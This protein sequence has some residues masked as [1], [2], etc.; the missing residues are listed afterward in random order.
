MSAS[1]R[2][3]DQEIKV[4]PTYTLFELF[5]V[6]FHPLGSVVRTGDIEGLAVTPVGERLRTISGQHIAQKLPGGSIILVR[7]EPQVARVCH[8]AFEQVAEASGFQRIQ[9]FG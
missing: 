8:A 2:L 6:V 9:A 4:S 3:A 5:Q 1:Q 7:V